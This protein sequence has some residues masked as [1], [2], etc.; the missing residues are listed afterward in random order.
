MVLQVAFYMQTYKEL[1]VVACIYL[2]CTCLAATAAAPLASVS[3]LLGNQTKPIE[4]ACTAGTAT[5]RVGQVRV[6]A[7]EREFAGHD[8]GKWE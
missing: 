8:D 2:H 4:L 5:Q 3:F 6:P 7:A 1:V